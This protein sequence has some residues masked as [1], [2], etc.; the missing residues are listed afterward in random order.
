MFNAL[1]LSSRHLSTALPRALSGAV[2]ALPFL[3]APLWAV[4]EE[5]TPPKPTETTQECADGHVWDKKT[6]ACVQSSSE[7]LDDDTRYDAVR[8][9]AYAGRTDSALSV[10]DGADAKDSPRFLTYRGFALRKQGDFDGAMA[11]YGAALAIEPDNIL[12]RS[13]MAQGLLTKGRRDEAVEILHQIEDLDG[14][15]TWAHR[16]LVMALDG[17]PT[18]Y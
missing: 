14:E 18:D 16:S 9:L 1:H 15:G 8:E 17:Q 12:A 6:K 4:G 7:L 11:A 3:A 13:Y 5:D 10:I 2:M